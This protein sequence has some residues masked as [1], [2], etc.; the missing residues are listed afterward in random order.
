MN[1]QQFKVLCEG[2][3]YRKACERIKQLN[4]LVKDIERLGDMLGQTK[5]LS[6]NIY[7]AIKEIAGVHS[8]NV[9]SLNILRS[10]TSASES[11]TDFHTYFLKFLVDRSECNQ[12]KDKEGG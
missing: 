7:N 4:E 2:C 12:N 3:I 8:W 5:E 10:M 11:Y 6:N 1:L 9:D